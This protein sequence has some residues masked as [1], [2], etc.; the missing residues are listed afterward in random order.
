M[1]MFYD[2]SIPKAV[3]GPVLGHLKC[4]LEVPAQPR[5]GHQ[6]ATVSTR[7]RIRC[8]NILL[9]TIGYKIFGGF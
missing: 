8:L 6:T 5:S 2:D 7:K 3:T 9:Q 4:R 1:G